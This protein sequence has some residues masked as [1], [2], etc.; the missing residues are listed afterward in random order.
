MV[1]NA[2]ENEGKFFFCSRIE[3][4]QNLTET[5]QMGTANIILNRRILKLTGPSEV[6]Q[7]I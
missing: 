5:M 2:Y 6:R 1:E 3:E 4:K 7:I